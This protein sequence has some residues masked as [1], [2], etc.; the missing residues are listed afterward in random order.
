MRDDVKRAIDAIANGPGY[1]GLEA[2]LEALEEIE[3]Y[4]H[5]LADEIAKEIEARAEGE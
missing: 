4:V 2:K 3:N 1:H 5:S